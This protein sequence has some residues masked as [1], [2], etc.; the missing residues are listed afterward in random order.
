VA[1][2]GE[3][4]IWTDTK[5]L[6]GLIIAEGEP[7]NI[8]GEIKSRPRTQAWLECRDTSVGKEPAADEALAK[9]SA[10][11]QGTDGALRLGS[12]VLHQYM[13]ERRGG[14]GETHIG[15]RSTLVLKCQTAS[16]ARSSQCS[17]A[18]RIEEEM[19]HAQGGGPW[20]KMENWVS[21]VRAKK[22]AGSALGVRRPGR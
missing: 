19:A 2:R 9:R 5:S 14:A 3:S 16:G 18:E 20:G 22:A 8:G 21:V 15:E 17:L 7:Q 10:M 1:Q 6:K 4:Q 12:N 13:T 11:N